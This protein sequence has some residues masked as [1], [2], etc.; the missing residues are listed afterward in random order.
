MDEFVLATGY[1]RK[2]DLKPLN[3]PIPAK[4]AAIRRRRVSPYPT[5]LDDL[6]FSWVSA[7][8]ICARLLVPFLPER[9]S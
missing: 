4:P 2:Y 8:W 1:H 3:G 9:V 5:I 6:T 7:N